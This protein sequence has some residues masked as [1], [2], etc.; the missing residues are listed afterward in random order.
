MRSLAGSR[1]LL[2]PSQRASALIPAGTVARRSPPPGAAARRRCRMPDARRSRRGRRGRG[3]PDRRARVAVAHID[4]PRH[5]PAD[6]RLERGAQLDEIPG[7]F[8]IEHLLRVLDRSNV[9]GAASRLRSVPGSTMTLAIRPENRMSLAPIVS[10]TRSRL[11][12]ARWR[13]AMA[14]VLQ[15]G[16]LRREPSRT[17]ALVPGPGHSL[18]RW[19][20]RKPLSMV[21]P[22]QPSGM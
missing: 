1:Q 20:S 13:R 9:A 16:D 11:R 18:A 6:E 2:P 4:H 5:I 10:S 3:C 7:Q 8:A 12:S 14:T 21:A 15:L 19:L 22:V 17:G